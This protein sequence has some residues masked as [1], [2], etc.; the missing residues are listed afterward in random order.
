MTP[1][2]LWL[3]PRRGRGRFAAAAS[4]VL[5]PHRLLT[6]REISLRGAS[7]PTAPFSGALH[8]LPRSAD[9]GSADR[10]PP[11]TARAPRRARSN[12]AAVRLVPTAL[13]AQADTCVSR[14]TPRRSSRIYIYYSI[15]G[16]EVR[17]RSC[18]ERVARGQGPGPGR[19]ASDLHLSARV[20]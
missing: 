6:K 13:P 19:F 3:E 10:T 8:P 20:F 7:R 16:V 9:P 2:A 15:H 5:A 14:F 12:R 11:G 18:V 1:R 17:S 4:I